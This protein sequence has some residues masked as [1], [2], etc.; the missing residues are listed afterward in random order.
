MTWYVI[1]RSQTM[2]TNEKVLCENGVLSW[3]DKAV[4]VLGAMQ[5]RWAVVFRDDEKA[6]ALKLVEEW[7]KAEQGWEIRLVDQVEMDQLTIQ[8]DL[9]LGSEDPR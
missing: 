8:R 6:A 7:Q 1:Y 9:R 3:P 4:D 5:S 2:A